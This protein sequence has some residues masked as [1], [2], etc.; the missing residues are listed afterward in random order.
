M[1]TDTQPN[2]LCHLKEGDVMMRISIIAICYLAM[3][4]SMLIQAQQLPSSV[5]VKQWQDSWLAKWQSGN[6]EDKSEAMSQLASLMLLLDTDAP[7]IRDLTDRLDTQS[8]ASVDAAAAV[9]FQMLRQGLSESGSQ[10]LLD[11]ILKYP[12]DPRVNRFRIGLARAFR[13]DGQFDLAAAQLEPIMDYK[14][15]DG[16]WATLERA[17]LY[18]AMNDDTD[19]IRLLEALESEAVN[20]YL[21]QIAH[22]EK[23][24]ASFSRIVSR[25]DAEGE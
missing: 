5:S 24:E 14:T 25:E 6:T 13:Q 17:R 20:D 11:L 23:L 10:R 8:D 3:T 12:S 21:R 19:A 9:G 18:R 15:P 22:T 4:C 1:G 7:L 2:S 16:R